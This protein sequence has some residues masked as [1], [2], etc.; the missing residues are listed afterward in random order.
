[1]KTLISGSPGCLLRAVWLCLTLAAAAPAL[2]QSAPPPSTSSTSAPLT[3]A[4][5]LYVSPKNGQTV[6]QQA[7]DRYACYTCGRWAT[8]AG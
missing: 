5:G 2:S 4:G 1:M 7:A 6:D 3:A 8:R